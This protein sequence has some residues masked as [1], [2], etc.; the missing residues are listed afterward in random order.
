MR[1][2]ELIDQLRKHNRMRVVMIEMATGH[3]TYT[4]PLIKLRES[5]VVLTLQDYDEDNRDSNT[6]KPTIILSR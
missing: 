2:G 5:G 6:N 1:V 4:R 3:N